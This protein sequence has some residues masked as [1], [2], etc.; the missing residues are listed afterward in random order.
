MSSLIESVLKQKEKRNWKLAEHLRLA[1]FHEIINNQQL[2]QTKILEYYSQISEQFPLFTKLTSSSILIQ[3]RNLV[4]SQRL[5]GLHLPF[6]DKYHLMFFLIDTEE[7]LQKILYDSCE[8]C[9]KLETKELPH[10]ELRRSMRINMEGKNTIMLDNRVS[11]MR[12]DKNLLEQQ[13]QSMQK[14]I[15]ATKT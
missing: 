14:F 9:E 4:E 15:D 5:Y 12:Q 1:G 7:P 10:I 8:D 6:S 2:R 3:N 11:I 13:Y